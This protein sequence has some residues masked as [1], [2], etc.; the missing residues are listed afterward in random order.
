MKL[1]WSAVAL[2]D[3]DRFAAFLHDRHPRLAA[4]VAREILLKAQILEDNP[5]LGRRLS[6]DGR[7]RQIV[8]DVLRAKYVFRYRVAEDRIVMLRVFHGRE[9]R[10]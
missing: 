4:I 3:L 2:A 7:F 1:E 10:R 6:V 8:L 9:E 5:E